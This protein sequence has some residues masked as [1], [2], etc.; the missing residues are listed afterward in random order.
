MAAAG[1]RPAVCTALPCCFYS[2]SLSSLPL[3]SALHSV[4]LLLLLCFCCCC[5]QHLFY[6]IKRGKKSLYLRCL[7]HLSL[8]HSPFHFLLP[9]SLPHSFSISCSLRAL[10]A[11]YP[12]AVFCFL[13]EL[14]YNPCSP[15][16]ILSLRPHLPLTFSWLPSSSS[17]PSL[18][19]LSTTLTS[20][21][22]C[23]FVLHNL[24][25][26]K[27]LDV[28]MCNIYSL[29]SAAVLA[30]MCSISSAA[31]PFYPCAPSLSPALMHCAN[32]LSE[33]IRFAR[34]VSRFLGFVKR[35]RRGT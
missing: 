6:F 24:Y 10:H 15:I 9:L 13:F 33:P 8:A 7:L 3:L 11:A 5:S 27:L 2:S 32:A 21:L 1:W 26:S 4:L 35:I 22:F 16:L 14:N 12:C 18:L 25:S 23:C 30:C 29:S 19:P 20:F 17:S 34:F 31:T 28:H